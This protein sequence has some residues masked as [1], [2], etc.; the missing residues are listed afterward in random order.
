MGDD[1]VDIVNEIKSQFKRKHKAMEYYF[2]FDGYLGGIE[3]K[4]AKYLNEV[5]WTLNLNEKYGDYELY[6]ISNSS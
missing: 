4:D 2:I 5:S 3:V 6:M 1:E